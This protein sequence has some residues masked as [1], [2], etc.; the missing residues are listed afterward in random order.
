MKILHV[1][2]GRHLHGGARQVLYLMQGLAERGFDNVLVCARGSAVASA[3]ANIARVVTLPWRGE[4][5]ALAALRLLRV[6]R[7]EAPAILHAHSRRGAD[8]FTALAA[9]K[10]GVPAVVS[11]RVDNVETG[12]LV[13]W[14]YRQYR[15]VIAISAAIAGVLRETLGDGLPPLRLVHSAVDSQAFAPGGDR[16]WL[17]AQ[18]GLDPNEPIIAMVAQFI[19]RKG[20]ALLL[21][22]LPAVWQRHPGLQCLLLG[23]GPEQARIEAQVEARGWTSRVRLPGFR[24]DM[25]R[26]LPALDMLVH[27]ALTEGLGVALLEAGACG[28]PVVAAAAGGIPE[29]IED[30]RTGLLVP[31]GASEPLAAAMLRVLEDPALAA[32]LGRAARLRVERDFSIAAMATAHATLYRELATTGGMR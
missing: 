8:W 18:F 26:I 25:A 27:P 22:A 15:A 4:A 2:T 29:V 32:Q 16:A 13:R 5:D 23:R 6:V 17:A 19:P 9:A 24:S 31:P 14:K 7:E 11:R 1:E 30:G 20:H 21:D 12:R 3:A 28:I 10:S